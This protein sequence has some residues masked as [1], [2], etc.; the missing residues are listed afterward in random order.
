MNKKKESQKLSRSA[1]RRI[2]EKEY[3]YKTILNSASTLI[4][5]KGYNQASIEEIADLAEVSVGTVYFY[6]KNKEDLLINLIEELGHVLRDFLGDKFKKAKTPLA[7]FQ[8]A[9]LAFFEEFC[10]SHIDM[11]AI[12]FREAV[13]Q[14]PEVEAARKKLFYVLTNDLKEALSAINDN[15]KNSAKVDFSLEVMAVCIVGIYEKVAYHYLLCQNR[16]DDMK[17]IGKNAFAFI[18]EGI[19]SRIDTAKK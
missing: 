19:N 6:F 8:K 7:G 1:Q 3:R 15:T 16:T 10:V 13:G 9:G 4:S 12:L 2:R 14:G 5:Q 17:P 11:T 18:M